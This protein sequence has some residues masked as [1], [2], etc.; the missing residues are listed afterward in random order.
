MRIVIVGAGEVSIR[1]AETLLEQGHE[2][3]I[4]ESEK[5]KI[6]ELANDLDCSFLHGDGGKPSILREVGPKQTDVLMCLTDNDQ[7]NI[8]ASLIGKSLGFKRIITNIEDPDLE[9]ICQELELTGTIIPSKTISRYLVDA[10]RDVDILELST[11]LKADARFF[12]FT[13]GESKENSKSD[14]DLPEEA[15]VIL[16][17]RKDKFHFADQKTKF[18]QGDELVILT[19]SKTLPELTERWKPSKKGE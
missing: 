5:S 10:I 9:S 2:I 11:I 19:R 6:D 14:L 1:T 18:Q 15:K 13:F 3:V 7:A 17:Y 12:S 4:I 8:I 16:Y